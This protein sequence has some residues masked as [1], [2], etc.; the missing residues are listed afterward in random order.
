M[1][2]LPFKETSLGDNQYIREFS[3]DVDNQELEW[4]IDREDRIVEVIYNKDWQ[5]QFDNQLPI[6]LKEVIFIPKETYHRIIKGTD[7]LIVKI[8]KCL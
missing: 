2:N 8:K 3:N 1:N 6:L 4:H 5:L 7:K